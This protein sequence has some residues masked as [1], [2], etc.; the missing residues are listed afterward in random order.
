MSSFQLPE[1]QSSTGK[2][3]MT[4]IKEKDKIS[5][6]SSLLLLIQDRHSKC[7]AIAHYFN[8]RINYEELFEKGV[9]PPPLNR[10]L[11]GRNLDWTRVSGRNHTYCNLTKLGIGAKFSSFLH[12]LLFTLLVF[13]HGF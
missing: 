13:K 3:R 2:I 6:V 10:L 8:L 1:L 4:R 9:S 7:F 11:S 5:I 12:Y